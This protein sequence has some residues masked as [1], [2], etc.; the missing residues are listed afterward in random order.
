MGTQQNPTTNPEELTS[1]TREDRYPVPWAT[2]PAWGTYGGPPTPH[3]ERDLSAIRDHLCPMCGEGFDPREEVQRWNGYRSKTLSAGASDIFPLHTRCMKQAR[4]FCPALH[5][6]PEE[7]FT[8]GPHEEVRASSE[9]DLAERVENMKTREA[10]AFQRGMEMATGAMF[11]KNTLE[12]AS[13]ALKTKMRE[14]YKC[15][16]PGCQ[17]YPRSGYIYPI[18]SNTGKRVCQ[19][20]NTSRGGQ[21]W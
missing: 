6:E 20:H 9:K 2:T 12:M 17:N 3:E 8:T 14:H 11:A 16:E 4:R 18:D 10:S 13:R 15:A 19:D 5:F 1:L 21:I 7:Q